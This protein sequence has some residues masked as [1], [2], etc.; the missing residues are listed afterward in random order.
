[1]IWPQTIFTVFNHS[2]LSITVTSRT[3]TQSLGRP[4]IFKTHMHAL[5]GF[6]LHKSL[7][8]EKYIDFDVCVQKQIAYMLNVCTVRTVWAITGRFITQFGK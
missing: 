8:S 4:H 6:Q 3:Q 2:Q 1:M 5:Q 7:I